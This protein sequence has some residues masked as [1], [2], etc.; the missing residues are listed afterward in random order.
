[1]FTQYLYQYMKNAGTEQIINKKKGSHTSWVICWVVS[2]GWNTR[3]LKLNWC[4]Q[5]NMV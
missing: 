5:M 2:Y 1:M 4:T 3:R